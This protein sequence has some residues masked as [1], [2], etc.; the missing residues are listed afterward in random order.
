[1]LGARVRGHDGPGRREALGRARF[2]PVGRG[3]G[4][5]SRR[6]AGGEGLQAQVLA[7][8]AR[9]GH[10]HL[11]GRTAHSL[12]HQLAGLAGRFQAAL[13]GGGVGDA[14]VDDH[15]PGA[16]VGRLA[17]RALV[18]MLAG[19]AHRGGAEHVGGEGGRRRAGLVGHHEGHVEPLGIGTEARMGADGAKTEGAGSVALGMIGEGDLC[20]GIRSLDGVGDL[21]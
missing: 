7:D 15:S 5:E 1:M 6:H 18:Q 10:E 3:Q 20:H 4:R 12:A 21:F 8:D 2:G 19:H 13:A 9:G 14:R 11:V 16:A 17:G